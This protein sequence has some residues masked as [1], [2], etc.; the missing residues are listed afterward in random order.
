M[1]NSKIR[2]IILA[3]ASVILIVSLAIGGTLAWLTAKSDVL[4]NTFT[5]G[6]ITMTLDEADNTSTSDGR[7]VT[8]NEYKVLPGDTIV[9]DPTLTIDADSEDCYVF[10][11]IQNNLPVAA[12]GK[13]GFEIENFNADLTEVDTIAAKN[14]TIYAYKYNSTDEDDSFITPDGTSIVIFD[15]I[16]FPGD[17]DSS[18]YDNL[19]ETVNSITTGKTIKIAA[20]AHQATNSDYDTAKAA[21]IAFFNTKF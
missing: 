15:G 20:F 3:V 13:I 16:E 17:I 12:T 4:T 10:I 21:A 5:I 9:K 11:A 8:G 19:V 18:V 7:T 6:Q 2:M 14:V 1:K